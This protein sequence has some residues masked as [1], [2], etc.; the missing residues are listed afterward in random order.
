MTEEAIAGAAHLAVMFAVLGIVLLMSIGWRLWYT[1]REMRF[2]DAGQFELALQSDVD[3]FIAD[4]QLSGNGSRALEV[5][6][7]IRRQ[8]GHA[9][10]RG[11]LVWAAAVVAGEVE[12][13]VT[14]PA[15][16]PGDGL[17]EAS[18]KLR[19]IRGKRTP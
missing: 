6:S 4:A 17:R 12:Q 16:V 18:D 5:L 15:C 7:E 9:L 3:A 14:V 1:Y 13:T 8:H 11:H 10:R 19:L 2:A